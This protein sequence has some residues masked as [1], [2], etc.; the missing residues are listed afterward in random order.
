MANSD[1]RNFNDYDVMNASENILQTI[2]WVMFFE[3]FLL[4]LEK[5]KPFMTCLH[6]KLINDLFSIL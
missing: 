6:T 4:F 5:L 3:F 2:W 1:P